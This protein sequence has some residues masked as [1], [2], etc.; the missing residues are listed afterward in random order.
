MILVASLLL[1]LASFKLWGVWGLILAAGWTLCAWSI[2]RTVDS[3][4]DALTLSTSASLQSL[5]QHVSHSAFT[6]HRY[7]TQE[8]AEQLTEQLQ[9]KLG[10]LQGELTRA[11][12]G[13]AEIDD[14]LKRLEI[15]GREL[16]HRVQKLHIDVEAMN[17]RI[18]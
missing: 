17:A 14:M 16:R 7:E 1:M 13:L 12:R 4:V 3:A 8:L 5:A 11:T 9:N 6:P 2:P 10:P 18:P 15:A